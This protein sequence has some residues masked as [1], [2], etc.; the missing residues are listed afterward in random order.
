VW[1]PGTGQ[2]WLKLATNVTVQGKSM[3]RDEVPVVTG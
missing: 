3:G 1:R 2:W